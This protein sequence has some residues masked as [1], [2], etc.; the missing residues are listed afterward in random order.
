VRNDKISML[1]TVLLVL[2]KE[3]NRVGDFGRHGAVRMKVGLM[4]VRFSAGL[5]G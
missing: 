1:F 4:K 2:G 3:W 5:S